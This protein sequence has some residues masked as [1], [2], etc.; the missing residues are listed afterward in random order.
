MLVALLDAGNCSVN[1]IY[2]SGKATLK[3]FMV[4]APWACSTA[5]I[6]LRPKRTA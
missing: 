5:M 3:L 4:L 6:I 2:G 1:K